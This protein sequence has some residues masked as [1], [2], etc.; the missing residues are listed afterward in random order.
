MARSHGTGRGTRNPRGITSGVTL[1]TIESGSTIDVRGISGATLFAKPSGITIAAGGIYYN[2]T[3]AITPTEVGKLDGIA[4][5]ALAGTAVG[6][7]VAGGAVTWAGTSLAI[8]TGLTTVTSFTA[9]LGNI[10]GASAA[11]CEWNSTESTAGK[12]TAALTSVTTTNA[13]ILCGSGGS[14][15]WIAFGT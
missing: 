8:S 6:G 15:T 4:G 9:S 13:V 7:K 11:G 10:S 2:D 5:A 12:V 1:A 14:I 3:T